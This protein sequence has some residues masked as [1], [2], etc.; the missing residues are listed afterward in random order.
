MPLPCQHKV[1]P[2]TVVLQVLAT[3]LVEA[4]FATTVAN[5][6]QAQVA[7]INVAPAVVCQ[8]FLRYARTSVLL[9]RSHQRGASLLLLL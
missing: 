5:I 2:L 4:N 3:A 9:I 8:Y 6:A 1:L 7:F